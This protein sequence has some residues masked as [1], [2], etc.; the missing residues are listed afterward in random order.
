VVTG[1]AA[2][3]AIGLLV[4]AARPLVLVL[5]G[6]VLATFGFFVAHA[7]A[8]GWVGI[9]V[10]AARSQATAAYSLLYYLGSAIVGY[11]GAVVYTATN[12]AG[13]AALVAGCA[14][15]A[16]V[17]VWWRTPRAVVGSTAR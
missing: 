2:V 8:A 15:L 9:L 5:V 7:V 13:V 1:G 4:L 14:S 17:A 16:A 10:P 12:W 11:V 6:L 3:M